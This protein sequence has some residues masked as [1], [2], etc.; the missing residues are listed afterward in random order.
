MILKASAVP[1]LLGFVGLVPAGNSLVAG[2]S[3]VSI[4]HGDRSHAVRRLNHLRSYSS[5]VSG[6]EGVSK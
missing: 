5:F 6:L 3:V 1:L 4:Y 2:L